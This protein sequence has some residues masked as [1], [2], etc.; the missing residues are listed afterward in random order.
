MA[1]YNTCPFCGDNLDPG[2]HCECQD[3]RE[4]K[5]RKRIA[6]NLKIEELLEAREWTQEE[7]RLCC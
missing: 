7:L 1:F 4:K 3:I 2:E 5:R 6:D